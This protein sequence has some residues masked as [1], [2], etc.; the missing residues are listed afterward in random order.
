MSL[1]LPSYIYPM[2]YIAIAVCNRDQMNECVIQC[3]IIV[4]KY[5][6]FHQ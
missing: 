5:I 3:L 2:V 6:R 1:H 4:D